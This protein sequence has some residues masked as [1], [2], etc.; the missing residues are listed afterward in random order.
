M[1]TK[2]EKMKELSRRKFLHK[3]G[4]TV[5]GVAALATVPTLT[6]CGSQESQV[7]EA[8]TAA[9]TE[10]ATTVAATTA[11]AAENVST[12]NI[13]AITLPLE[14]HE[15]DKDAVQARVYE[16]WFKVGGC[17]ASVVDG[18]F[19]S[20]ADKYGY[21]YNHFPLELGFLGHAGFNSGTYCGSLAGATLAIS[22]FIPKEN[23][24]DV[25]KQLQSWYTSTVL[26]IYE[27]EY[28]DVHTTAPSVNCADSLGTWMKAAG[29]DDRS[30]PRRKS[31]CAALS[32]DAAAKV[33][34][35]INVFY[36]IEKPVETE[37]ETEEETA[38]N[39]Y[40]ASAKGMEGDVKVKV[41]VD[42]GKI[43]DVKVLSHNETPNIGTNAI[44]AIPEKFIGLS[45][46]EE[47]DGVDAVSGATITSD[48]LKEAV[49]SALAQA[50]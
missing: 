31:R 5:L 11:A 24:D 21:P 49:K 1:N 3:A 17:G 43:S 35:L 2:G 42:D 33:V 15:L 26:P 37:A 32:A 48:A 9:A 19:G 10:A 22:L 6:G 13:P 44:D 14:W 4:K 20:L 29:V 50:K 18:I 38:A 30:D 39:E 25:L 7:P 47:I 40:I 27:G 16:Q 46:P 23:Q 41:T 36:G 28:D 8:S 34:E 45:T 12:Q